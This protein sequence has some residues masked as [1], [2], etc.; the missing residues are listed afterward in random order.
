MPIDPNRRS[1]ITID[2]RSP[3]NRLRWLMAVVAALVVLAVGIAIGIAWRGRAQPGVELVA[4]APASSAAAPRTSA[5]ATEIPASAADAP[6]ASITLCD[7]TRVPLRAD[8]AP[9]PS[10]YHAAIGYDAV[11]DRTLAA[12]RASGSD[13]G[14]LA[15]S[16]LDEAMG[17][18]PGRPPAARDRSALLDAHANMAL[19]TSDPN[20]YALV[21]GE[22]SR[23][24]ST[25]CGMVTATHW[26]EL[27]P[28]NVY[29][30]LALAEEASQRDDEA[31]E[32]K[33]IQRAARATTASE[34][35][36]WL[37]PRILA[38]VPDDRDAALA[39]LDLSLVAYDIDAS[40]T[41]VPFG[42]L[43][44]VC[45]S[46]RTTDPARRRA[47]AAIADT[48]AERSETL[49]T[50]NLGLGVASR[51][52][53]HDGWPRDRIDRLRGEG[54]AWLEVDTGEMLPVWQ[55]DQLYACGVARDRLT[56]LRALAGQTETARLRAWVAASGRSAEDFIRL[57]REPASAPR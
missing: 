31:A 17:P 1:R 28:D 41:W 33:A 14:T 42:M 43:I 29:A 30:W 27:A 34:G 11:V 51:L 3:A 5:S 8:G 44:R 4:H 52:D 38:S 9:E 25:L 21:Y 13:A 16:L 10:A 7:G 37:V 12:L 49:I 53:A 39:A 19:A 6:R 48:M 45:S 56:R 36:A 46:E 35:G 15:A 47:C 26:T 57:A 22:C 50:R 32:E 2:A 40:R 18:A 24:S 23:Q 54:K 55:P 20:V